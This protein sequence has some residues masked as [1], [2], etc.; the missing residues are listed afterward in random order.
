MLSKVIFQLQTEAEFSKTAKYLPL[1][2]F[3][4]TYSVLLCI[5]ATVTITCTIIQYFGTILCI[6]YSDNYMTFWLYATSDERVDAQPVDVVV[7]PL[8][9]GREQLSN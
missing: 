7:V 9:G 2:N 6:S 1:E 3:Q 8:L 5:L 4:D